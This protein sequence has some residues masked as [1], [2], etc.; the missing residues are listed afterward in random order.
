M[1]FVSFK[2]RKAPYKTDT[3]FYVDMDWLQVLGLRTPLHLGPTLH[4]TYHKNYLYHF[5]SNRDIKQ[6][7]NFLGIS[8]NCPKIG[9]ISSGFLAQLW[10]RLAPGNRANQ[11]QYHLQVNKCGQ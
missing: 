4:K 3:T 9:H 11:K 7:Y 2:Y 1:F 10:S 8:N 6:G 5:I